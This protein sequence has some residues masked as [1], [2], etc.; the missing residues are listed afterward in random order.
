LLG[1]LLATRAGVR[2][3][4]LLKQQITD[5]LGMSDTVVS[6]SP[7]QQFRLIQGYDA[8]HP[9]PPDV[10]GMAGSGAIRSTAGDVLK[11]LEANLHP[12]KLG[13]TLPEAITMTHQPRAPG[14]PG[15]TIGLAW[16]HD[17]RQGIWW[18]DGAM[19]GFTS[20]AFFDPKGDYAAVILLNHGPDPAGLAGLLREYIRQ[21][22]T[23]EPAISLDAVLVPASK[24]LPGTLRWFAA[25]W[26]TMLAAG[27]FIYCCVL[28]V[29]GLAAQLLPRRMFLRVSGF[30]QLATFC[31]FVCGYFLQPVF[32]GL[33]GLSEP[34]VR[35]LLAWLPSYWFLGLIH[36]LN[37]SPH[38]LLASLARR[39]WIG[40][41][42]A[43][44]GTAAAYALSYLRTL[45]KIVEE[46]DITP[47]S[48]GTVWLP[49][50][51]NLEQTAI[52]QFSVRTLA[53]S[54][55]H[56]VILAFY[57]GIGFAF[58]IFLLRAPDRKVTAP[59]AA[60]SI[61]MMALAVVGTRVVF[62]MPKDLRANW[63]F[64][65]TALRSGP[66]SLTAARRSLLLLSVLPVWLASA[67]L[68][69]RLWPWQQAAGHL[70]VLGLIGILLSDVCLYGFRKIPFTCSYLPGKSRVN[71]VFLAA[72]GLVYGIMGAVQV[73]QQVLQDPRA[74]LALVT[75]FAVAAAAVRLG[76][77]RTRSDDDELQFEESAPPAIQELGLRGHW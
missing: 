51:G 1:D 41:A 27:G 23:G 3:S 72:L 38:P 69:L 65:V 60:A 30:L 34:G 35:R 55:Q 50:F 5:P 28:G 8:A 2:Y 61:V 13:G 68:C 76:A 58:T 48:R 14:A 53:R 26:F 42:I 45:R 37:G 70:A 74:T 36:D 67:V 62:A 21:R 11:Y 20:S 16:W 12:E 19:R 77:I 4:E 47:A 63:I 46:P 33:S 64:R 31:L 54:R 40:L 73:E 6:L 24:G 39:A 52:G 15:T 75:S 57:L 43:L 18:H 56:R 71:M 25:Y 59:G 17:A 44:S 29:Q 49:R 9:V 22:L 32:G 7:G 66:R 10:E